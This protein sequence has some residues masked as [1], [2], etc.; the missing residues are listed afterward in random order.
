MSQGPKNRVIDD[1]TLDELAAIDWSAI[2]SNIAWDV[3]CDS[4]DEGEERNSQ[5]SEPDLVSA[6][7]KHSEAQSFQYD[8]LDH[9]TDSIRLIDILPGAD[10]DIIQ[11][12]IRHATVSGSSYTCLSYTW[13]PDFPK[14]DIEINGRCLPV[15]ENLY[16]FLHAYRTY[17]SQTSTIG[18]F[19]LHYGQTIESY[20]WIDGICICQS[21][22]DEKGHQV[23]QMGAIYN[24][25]DHVLIWLG[26]PQ[27][28]LDEI[29]R[30]LH[31]IY[32]AKTPY[33]APKDKTK[34]Q[35]HLSAFYA[36]PYWSR[37]W[38][39]QEVL[40]VCGAPHRKL[41]IFTGRQLIDFDCLYRGIVRM[42]SDIGRSAIPRLNDSQYNKY[43]QYSMY[44]NTPD[45]RFIIPA[46]LANLL[47][48]FRLGCRDRRDR[49][50][51][52]L[53][54]SSDASNICVNYQLT[55]RQLFRHILQLFIDK[56][57]LDESLAF[58]AILI[59]SLELQETRGRRESTTWECSNTS[60]GAGAS[61]VKVGNVGWRW[62]GRLVQDI[63][64]D[65]EGDAQVF[66]DCIVV[67][68]LD[69]GCVHLFEY[70]IERSGYGHGAQVRYA[71][72]H[73]FIHGLP[74]WDKILYN[75]EINRPRTVQR[76]VQWLRSPSENLYYHRLT[77][78]RGSGETPLLLK[79]ATR[80]HKTI[81]YTAVDRPR[82]DS[83]QLQIPERRWSKKK[84]RYLNSHTRLA[85]DLFPEGALPR[86]RVEYEQILKDLPLRRG[87]LIHVYGEGRDL[88]ETEFLIDSNLGKKAH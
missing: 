61:A 52:L 24:A 80:A 50:F 40:L 31:E 13:E 7:Y 64:T 51:A 17:M 62:S 14:H 25:A 44:R 37:L 15:G 81:A 41:A 20:L 21:D 5:I 75:H 79:W 36:L 4:W 87:T 63:P 9:G 53:S 83:C 46:P 16:R 6:T 74:N 68:L 48:M 30:G 1:P 26:Q 49:I 69:N 28:S 76:T 45:D 86:T 47:A 42:T 12:T 70:A 77:H 8:R 71:R 55:R 2:A 33:M 57:T 73:E 10:D 32:A 58:G 19:H 23:R 29:I 60:P 34:Y 27:E 82:F 85:L 84:P 78:F 39:A 67:E 66:V 11:C 56:F 88:A 72:I 35:D 18:P 38:V 3:D 22:D 54:M 59:E 65:M 43:G